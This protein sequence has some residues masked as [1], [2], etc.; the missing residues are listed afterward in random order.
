MTIQDIEATRE[1]LMED[2]ITMEQLDAA[3]CNGPK[4]TKLLRRAK[5]NPFRSITVTTSYDCMRPGLPN[6]S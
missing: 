5:H 1:A 4:L 2:D 3:I 6:P